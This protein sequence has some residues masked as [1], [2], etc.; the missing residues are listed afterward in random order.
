MYTTVTSAAGLSTQSHPLIND[1]F[2]E[3]DHSFAPNLPLYFSSASADTSTFSLV[4]CQADA[5]HPAQTITV[6]A[7]RLILPYNHGRADATTPVV[8]LHA[9]VVQAYPNNVTGTVTTN[10]TA[11]PWTVLVVLSLKLMLSR[12]MQLNLPTNDWLSLHSFVDTRPVLDTEWTFTC[13][14]KPPADPMRCMTG[15]SCVVGHHL[16]TLL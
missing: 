4:T 15:D 6:A 8:S 2:Q 5:N 11:E 9:T 14:T 1:D 16:E 7:K 3:A 13:K 12:L 10:V